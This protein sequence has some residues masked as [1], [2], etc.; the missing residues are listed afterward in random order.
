MVKP[1]ALVNDAAPGAPITVNKVG[2]PAQSG[3]LGLA[4]IDIGVMVAG[5]TVT[6]AV[7]LF[8][9]PTQHGFP[10]SITD[11]SEYVVF[12]AGVT[13]IQSPLL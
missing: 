9:V 10:A 3:P 5:K 6:T 7:P 12:T 2:L 11:T 1:P 8:P 13:G 4:V